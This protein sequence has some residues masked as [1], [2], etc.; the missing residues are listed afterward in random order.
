MTDSTETPPVVSMQPS[1]WRHMR[2]RVSYAVALLDLKGRG[3][4]LIGSLLLIAWVSAGFYN[5]QPDEQGIVLRFGRWAQT[6][7]PGLHYHF[8]YPI[9]TVLKPK[10]TQV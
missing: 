1:S 7:E 4:R 9:E 10:V 8:P 3:L 5:V 6:T 2:D